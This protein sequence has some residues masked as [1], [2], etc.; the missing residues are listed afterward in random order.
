MECLLHIKDVGVAGQQRPEVGW[1]REGR[2]EGTR[3]GVDRRLGR[4]QAERKGW[5]FL[6]SLEGSVPS[7]GRAVQ[8]K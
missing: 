6:F 5:K 7:D 4:R 2:L 1:S 8:C 3:A